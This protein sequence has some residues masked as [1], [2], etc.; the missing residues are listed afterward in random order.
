MYSKKEEVPEAYL[1]REALLLNLTVWVDLPLITRLVNHGEG[2]HIPIRFSLCYN[3]FMSKN[4]LN[5]ESYKGVRDFYP[6]DYFTR[7]FMMD[8]M[9]KIAKLY[10]YEQYDA[11]ILEP[12]ELYKNKTSE[13]IVNEQTYTFTDRGGREVTLRPEMTPTIARMIAHKKNTL[14]LPIRWFSIPNLFRYERPQKGRLRE[15]WQFNVDIFGLS[16]ADAEIEIISL[17]RDLLKD[18]GLKDNDYTIRLSSR[19][20]TDFMFGEFLGLDKEN[21]K[22]LARLIDK[23][24]KITLKEFEDKAEEILGRRDDIFLGMV[25]SKNFEGFTKHLPKNEKL[26]KELENLDLIITGL[27]NLGINNVVLDQSLIRG[28]DYYTGTVFEFFDNDSENP[29]SL[30]GGGRFDKL[31]EIFDAPQIP[32]VGFG[33][34][35]VVLAE[36]LES[37]NLLP[38]YKKEKTVAICPLSNKTVSFSNE[39]AQNLRDNGIPVLVSYNFK[40]AG[41]QIKWADK[42]QVE[43]VFCVGDDEIESGEFIVKNLMSGKEEKIKETDLIK[44]FN[45]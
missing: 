26:D 35:D 3:I 30:L 28:F 39:I 36:A 43:S 33:M 10:G 11:S 8:K 17:G 15:H 27:N 13:E 18:L 45:K 19:V 25:F 7:R 5:T 44:F 41:E 24:T 37:R 34:G 38:K 1:P 21:T 32:T 40:K 4:K 23:K 6:T 22:N 31:L 16:G 42:H 12:S 2:F 9:E 14:P 20:I 29:R